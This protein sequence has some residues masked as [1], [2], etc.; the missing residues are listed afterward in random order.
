LKKVFIHAQTF[1]AL[2]KNHPDARLF[3]E[4][5]ENFFN[6]CPIISGRL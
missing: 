5:F 1:W 2:W 6:F 4:E 3:L